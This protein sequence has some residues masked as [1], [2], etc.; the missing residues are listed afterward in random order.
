MN[1]SI[2]KGFFLCTL[3]FTLFSGGKVCLAEN[4]NDFRALYDEELKKGLREIQQQYEEARSQVQ[5]VA[6]EINVQ[7]HYNSFIHE[8][9]VV[10]DNYCAKLDDRIQVMLSRQGE[11]LT[12]VQE[13]FYGN[14]LSLQALDSEYKS[15][16]EV[17]NGLLDERNQYGMLSTVEIDYDKL[18]QLTSEADR[19][20]LAYEES[21]DAV[22]LGDVKGVQ[23]PLGEASEI[24][25]KYGVRLDPMN[26]VTTRF[27]AG[28]DLKAAEGTQVLSIFNGTVSEAGWGPIG[29][30]YVRVDHGDGIGSYYCHLQKLL[31]KK[32]QEVKQY[33][34]IALSGNT[35]SRTTGPH[36]HF[37]LYI[38]GVSVDPAVL[39]ENK[40]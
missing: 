29:G 35:G 7:E 30:Y 25:S 39:L 10:Q 26:P 15:N 12:E 22:E 19:L 9:M 33:D 27:H 38:D 21:I 31:C 8:A 13:G 11:I 28:V 4:T 18:A 17:V 2:C 37:A 5:N 14:I 34:V 23:Y 3:G 32:G 24:R 6:E 16:V 1:R 40:E 36:L 20:F